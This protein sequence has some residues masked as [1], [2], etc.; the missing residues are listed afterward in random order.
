MSEMEVIGSA[1]QGVQ[2][3][4]VRLLKQLNAHADANIQLMNEVRLSL[5]R[6]VLV[7]LMLCVVQRMRSARLKATIS[8][9]KEALEAAEAVRS[10][11]AENVGRLEQRIATL[12]AQNAAGDRENVMRLS[13]I[14]A[15]RK[16]AQDLAQQLYETQ[17]RLVERDSNM[18][19]VRR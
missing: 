17:T 5:T 16:R 12:M 15:H 8:E 6:I 7:V 18:V 2:D 13:A 19:E 10:Q 1:F 4:N 3:Q 9:Q 14:E 11:H